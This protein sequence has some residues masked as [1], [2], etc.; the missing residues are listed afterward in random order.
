MTGGDLVRARLL[1]LSG[2]TSLVGTRVWALK[3]PQSPIL[4]AMVVTNVSDLQDLQLRGTD[5]LRVTRVQV[6]AVATTLDGARAVALAAFGTF[7]AGTATGLLGFR[8]SVAVGSPAP[9]VHV[10][11]P[12]LYRETYLADELKQYVASRDW[13]VTWGAQ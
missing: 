12:D 4:P 5:G 13:I 11:R 2:V 3:L 1:A 9:V 8:G 10:M 7:T 6:D